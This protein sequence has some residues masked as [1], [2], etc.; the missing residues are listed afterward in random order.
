MS[1][2]HKKKASGGLISLCMIVK[3]EAASLPRCLQ[4]V[5]GIV[6]QIVVVDTGSSDNSVAI[7]KRY[8]AE[9]VHARWTNDFAAARNTGLARAAGEWVLFLD[10]D[11]ELDAGTGGQLRMLARERAITGYFLNIWNYMGDSGS[12]GATIN[13]VL[14][15]FR[16]D[17]RYRFEGR[18]HEQIAGPITRHTPDARFHLSDVIIHHYGYKREVVIA[19][20]KLER[21]R[22]LLER[23]VVEEPENRFHWYNLGVEYFR[24]RALEDALRAFRQAR[25]GID[26]ASISYAHLLV[27]HEVQCLQALRRWQDSLALAEEGLA[28]YA[29][30]PDLWHAKGI[31]LAALG[32]RRK[33]AEAF[34]AAI[35]IGKAPAIYHTEDGM[36]S[37]Q[38]AYWLGSMHEAELDFETAAHWYAE[39]VR[40]RSSLLAPLYRLCHMM[41]IG[42]DEERLAEF[43]EQRFTLDSPQASLKL[44]DVMRRSGCYK[45]LRI[46]L[47]RRLADAEA[48]ERAMLQPWLS[49]AED[50]EA[51]AC[52]SSDD[53]GGLS[54]GAAGSLG[55]ALAWLGMAEQ[56]PFPDVALEWLPLLI[57]S[58]IAEGPVRD[59]A[60]ALLD[61]R[62]DGEGPSSGAAG[63]RYAAHALCALAD[64]HLAE[65]QKT[66]DYTRAAQEM[67]LLL[68]AQGEGD[69]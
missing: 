50:C 64:G 4:S 3:D 13:P 61:L 8:G 6:D 33:A 67:R 65:V 16:N 19:K 38:S 58:G 66:A 34:A 63:V 15:M 10:A 62:P 17:R 60:G 29:D 25:D 32:K 28:W 2:K 12:D 56:S 59:V 35:H 51:L 5:Q 21:N 39:A 47:T 54:T 68:P 7:A 57:R 26:Y 11:E 18:I 22:E 27:K 49:V 20:N 30:Y 14:R 52:G 45:A 9:V 1:S 69:R 24:G 41:R 42:G 55:Q 44:A 46:W 36:G 43:V 37:Y 48:T 31:G 53:D 23:A 40:F